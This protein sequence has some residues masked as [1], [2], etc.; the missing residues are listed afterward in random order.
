MSFLEDRDLD[1]ELAND[2][3]GDLGGGFRSATETVTATSQTRELVSIGGRRDMALKEGRIDL[4]PS[5][6]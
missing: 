4:A 3:R 2:S 6:L 1:G 5:R